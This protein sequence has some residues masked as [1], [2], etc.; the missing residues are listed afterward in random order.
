M[1]MWFSPL[2][3]GLVFL[4]RNGNASNDETRGCLP[5]VMNIIERAS[6]T[7]VHPEYA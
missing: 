2:P 6:G 3:R 4:E 7:N 1:E 5:K